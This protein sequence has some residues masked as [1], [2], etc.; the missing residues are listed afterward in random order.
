MSD[1]DV[2]DTI[3]EMDSK[4]QVKLNLEASIKGSA[5]ALGMSGSLTAKAIN[6]TTL[7][8]DGSDNLTA[9]NQTTTQQEIQM[10]P[11]K[12]IQSKSMVRH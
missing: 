1:E 9:T 7:K 8:N 10:G 5:S 12:A 2:E 4:D 11:F 3:E 6:S